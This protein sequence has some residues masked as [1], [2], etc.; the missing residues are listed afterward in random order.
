MKLPPENWRETSFRIG[1][2]GYWGDGSDVDFE[3]T[4]PDGNP[5]KMQQ[6]RFSRVGVYGSLYLGDLNLFGVAV[7]G[8][9]DLSLRDDETDAEISL[10]HAHLGRLV[11]SG[12]LRHHAA[13]PGFRS[14][15]R[16][17]GRPIRRWTRCR[18]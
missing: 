3:I 12:R 2:F 13:V 17:S 14:A 11:R 9:D 5:F 10:T 16:I 8:S 1:A 18:R 6:R 4:D 7:H 15:T